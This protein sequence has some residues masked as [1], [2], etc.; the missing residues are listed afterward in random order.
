MFSDFPFRGWPALSVTIGIIERPIRAWPFKR[1][2]GTVVFIRGMYRF[3]P[4][5][6]R[7]CCKSV[8]RAPNPILA[9]VGGTINHCAVPAQVPL[10]LL[11]LFQIPRKSGHDAIATR[12]RFRW[13]WLGGLLGLLFREKFPTCLGL[14]LAQEIVLVRL[15]GGFRKAPPA[16]AAAP[17]IVSK[18]PRPRELSL[19]PYCYKPRRQAKLAKCAY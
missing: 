9:Q 10:D 14:V 7:C 19:A 2:C 8:R 12:C 15:C 3:E 4:R 18:G 17:P 16:A 13:W 6:R 5:R 11:L 1:A